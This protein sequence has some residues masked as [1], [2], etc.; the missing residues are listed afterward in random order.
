[1]SNEQ[2]QIKLSRETAGQPSEISEARRRWV[3]GGLWTAPVLLTLPRVSSA[4]TSNGQGLETV[5]V[6]I[7]DTVNPA[8]TPYMTTTR[9]TYQIKEDALPNTLKTIVNAAANPASSSTWNAIDDW[10]A[11]TSGTA[12]DPGTIAGWTIQNGGASVGPAV[13]VAQLDSCANVIGYG[14]D[15]SGTITTATGSA[16]TSLAGNLAGCP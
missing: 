15:P 3:K 14:Y 7:A 8:S 2:E 16:W 10:T 5:S 1:M 6:T 12:N 4:T 9:N 11:F 13:L